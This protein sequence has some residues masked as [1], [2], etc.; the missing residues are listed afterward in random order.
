MT[1]CRFPFRLRPE[2]G[3]NTGFFVGCGR[4]LYCRIQR[5]KAWAMRLLYEVQTSNG[6]CFI[7]LTYDDKH[8]PAGGTLV[9]SDLQK[10]Y[11]RLRK[12]LGE[13]KIKHFS[14][15]EYGDKFNR[16][17][18]HGIVCGLGAG[19]AKD[20]IDRAWAMGRIDVGNAE[21]DSIRYVTGY[22]AKKFHEPV[23]E[24]CDPTFQLQSKGIGLQ[25]AIDN[26]EDIKRD[27]CKF[28]GKSQGVP[29]YFRDKLFSEEEVSVLRQKAVVLGAD[30]LLENFPEYGGILEKDLTAH[31]LSAVVRRAQDQNEQM[32]R[33][34][35]AEAKVHKLKKEKKDY[36]K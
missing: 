32:H 6:A 10:F 25:Y 13:T 18:Y 21:E 17:H 22:I 3:G 35:L 15:G 36:G 5:R 9:K 19:I 24:G 27:G 2:A 31:Q 34:L 33:H 12:I 30:Y 20:F 29:R 7:T 28:R 11:K 14:C 16:P 1:R 23:P 26:L 4:C 8:L